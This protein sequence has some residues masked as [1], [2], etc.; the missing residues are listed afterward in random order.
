[1]HRKEVEA[2]K[3]EKARERAAKQQQAPA[4]GPAV[5]DPNQ[6]R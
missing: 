6:P 4:S 2:N 3:A 5:A 1:V